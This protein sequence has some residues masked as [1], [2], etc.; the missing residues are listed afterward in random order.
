[1]RIDYRWVADDVERIRTSAEELVNFKPDVILAHSGLTVAQLQRQ[2]STIPIVFLHIV[3]PVATGF[4]K[5]WRDRA[6]TSPASLL[7]SFR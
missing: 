3:D 2:T 7:V 5:R 6:V 4:V 1:M